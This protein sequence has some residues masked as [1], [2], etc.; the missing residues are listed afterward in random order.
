MLLFSYFLYLPLGLLLLFSCIR[1][2]TRCALLNV[3]QTCVLPIVHALTDVLGRTS[4]AL[5][6]GLFRNAQAIGGAVAHRFATEAPLAVTAGFAYGGH[7]N[8]ALRVG[9]AGE[10]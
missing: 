8:N 4:Y 10:F 3:V 6:G 1:R 2:H 7:G 9:V 5:N